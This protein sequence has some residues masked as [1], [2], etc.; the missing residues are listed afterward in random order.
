MVN[1]RAIAMASFR[2]SGNAVLPAVVMRT[3]ESAPARTVLIGLIRI[4]CLMLLFELDAC[5]LVSLLTLGGCPVFYRYVVAQHC[6][7]GANGVDWW[8]G[9]VCCGSNG[10]PYW[11]AV[12]Y[13]WT[14]PQHMVRILLNPRSG[15]N[16]SRRERGGGSAMHVKDVLARF[17]HAFLLV[18]S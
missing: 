4:S 18:H 2:S 10:W 15:R 1:R 11:T 3:G 5:C 9:G 13:C 12:Y 6:R 16:N 14:F 17:L 7:E 8:N